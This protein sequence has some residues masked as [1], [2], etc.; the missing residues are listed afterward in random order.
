VDR[1][2]RLYLFNRFQGLCVFFSFSLTSSDITVRINPVLRGLLGVRPD[3]LSI[4]THKDYNRENMD[5][6]I[7]LLQVS[8]TTL[9]VTTF[10]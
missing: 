5:N 4:N 2:S 10:T 1:G 7:A 8:K 9:A 3:V 6:D